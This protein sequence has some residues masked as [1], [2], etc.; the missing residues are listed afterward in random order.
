[1]SFRTGGAEDSSSSSFHPYRPH[2]S[3]EQTQ[4]SSLSGMDLGSFPHPVS[5]NSFASVT[6]SSA[7]AHHVSFDPSVSGMLSSFQSN[8]IAHHAAD[9]EPIPVLD[10][11]TSEHLQGLAQ[12]SG[13]ARSSF[14]ASGMSADLEPTPT[15]SEG[16]V[17][18]PIQD[19]ELSEDP[20]TWFQVMH[21]FAQQPPTSEEKK[22]KAGAAAGA[23]RKKQV[24][25]LQTSGSAARV[26]R[27]KR[28]AASSTPPP[29]KA[30]RKVSVSSPKSSSSQGQQ[31]SEKW[32]QQFQELRKYKAEFGH[33]NVPNGWKRNKQLAQWYVKQ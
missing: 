19:E 15:L 23:K 4:A 32:D 31:Q 13:S 9:F 17:F 26:L 16:L 30:V 1:M 7:A 18:R 3:K 24:P 22:Q 14:G 33:C 29:K 8:L 21:P 27:K 25:P 20:S 11:L 10:I 28:K 2:Q 12:E 5:S 6:A